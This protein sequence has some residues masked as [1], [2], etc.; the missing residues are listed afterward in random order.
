MSS[1]SPSSNNMPSSAQENPWSPPLCAAI[2]GILFCIIVWRIYIFMKINTGFNDMLKEAFE[3]IHVYRNI[4]LGE[5]RFPNSFQCTSTYDSLLI[6]RF[7]LCIYCVCIWLK[8][9][10]DTN[11]HLYKAYTCWN[12][13][14]ITI[15]FICG[16]KQSLRAHRE[17][18]NERNGISTDTERLSNNYSSKIEN[19]DIV[20]LIAGNILL[21]S[22][23]IVTSVVW[24]VLYPNL[25]RVNPTLAN[26]HYLGINS[27]SQHIFNFVF[28]QLDF[29]L[30]T[31][32][33]I[34]ANLRYVLLFAVSYGIMFVIDWFIDGYAIY[35]FLA[36]DHALS[37]IFLLGLFFIHAL[38][39]KLYVCISK[40]KGK[41]GGGVSSSSSSNG[42]IRS[43]NNNDDG[44]YGELDTN[45]LID[46]ADDTL[47]QGGRF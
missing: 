34:D 47:E 40:C 4:K 25:H 12:W 32:P 33:V 43:S 24:F 30:S 36:L 41:Q 3:N 31:M 9:V 17:R 6:F 8:V 28:I 44:S 5:S 39:F 42:G 14:L 19:Y 38:L 20:H 13:T 21:V 45:S 2:I 23:I 22:T 10:F 1:P 15:F 46:N 29:Y 26:E 11:F 27:V 18:Q 35:P 37:S 16:T 7:I